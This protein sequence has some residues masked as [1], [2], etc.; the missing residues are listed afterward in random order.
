VS[1]RRPAPAF[2]SKEDY[3]RERRRRNLVVGGIA[4][5]IV[6]VALIAGGAFLLFAGDDD[7]G[8]GGSSAQGLSGRP[9]QAPSQSRTGT[10][11]SRSPALVGP[12]SRFVPELGELPKNYAILPPDTFSMT[13]LQYASVGGDFDTPEQGETL[14]T[15]WGYKDGYQAVYEPAGKLAEL[16]SGLYY[17]TVDTVL[18]DTDD[19]ARRLYNQMKAN[20]EERAGSVKV[21]NVK[22]LGNESMAWLFVPSESGVPGTIGT[23]DT[24][25]I[26]HRFVFRRGNLVVTV[27]TYG[28]EPY[29]NIDRARELAAVVDDRALG[30][31]AASTPTP[32][33]TSAIG[34]R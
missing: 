7:G 4:G 17:V 28:A 3:A 25:G 27:Q 12:A 30:G 9:T 34:A 24:V 2:R 22:G 8:G 33:P 14:L 19:G 16:L 26:Y 29:M 21:A 15:Q 1:S 5:A 20:Y 6:L 23:S 10:Q 31:R 32:R 18:F 13:P 11:D